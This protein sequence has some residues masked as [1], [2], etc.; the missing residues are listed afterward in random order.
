MAYQSVTALMLV[1]APSDVPDDD[2]ATVKRTVSQWNWNTGRPTGVTVVPVSWSEH[3]VAEFGDRPQ[4]VLNDQLVDDSD[5]AVA[6]FADR[7]GTPTGVAESG[8]LEEIYRL[9]EAGKHVSVLVNRG[10][11]SLKGEAAIEEKA[12]LEKALADLRDRAI[13]LEYTDQA[14]LSSHL[15]SMLSMVAG[16]LGGGATPM[17]V[18]PHEESVGVWPQGQVERHSETDNKG[19]LKEKSRYFIELSNQ[20]GRPV[21]GVTLTIPDDVNIG[22]LHSDESIPVLAPGARTR[23]PVFRSLGSDRGGDC[24]VSWHFEGEEPRETKGYISF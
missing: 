18:A 8:T 1:S 13:V 10:A 23:L 16:K 4:Q 19:K 15:N 24:T 11:R 7:L 5:M 12:R 22:V 14:G 17:V 3:A 21:Y 20:T 9:V 6:L 2:L